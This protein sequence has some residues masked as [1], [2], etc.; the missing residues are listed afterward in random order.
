MMKTRLI[1]SKTSLDSQ[2]FNSP[3]KIY[4]EEVLENGYTYGVQGYPFEYWML[5]PFKQE[6]RYLFIEGFHYGL[7]QHK[8]NVLE[9]LVLGD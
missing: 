9:K 2:L 1:M 5:N 7:V 8:R 4:A 6:Y 3:N